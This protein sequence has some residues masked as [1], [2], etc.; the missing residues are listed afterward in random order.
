[1]LV[2]IPIGG[3]GPLSRQ[4]GFSL[5]GQWPGTVPAQLDRPI[6][7]CPLPAEGRKKVLICGGV[8]KMKTRLPFISGRFPKFIPLFPDNIKRPPKISPL[9]R[10]PA[11]KRKQLSQILM[12]TQLTGKIFPKVVSLS[13][14]VITCSTIWLLLPLKA[15]IIQ[16]KH[17]M[18][19]Y[20]YRKFNNL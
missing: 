15:R 12:L 14:R 10:Q 1:M 5:D 7:I 8:W 18:S 20:T 4:G 6:Q 3:H 9:R 11:E 16:F 2:A 13:F 19:N 17:L